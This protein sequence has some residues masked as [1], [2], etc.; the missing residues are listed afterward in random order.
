MPGQKGESGEK[1]SQGKTGDRGSAGPQGPAGP[2]GEPGNGGSATGNGEKGDK[3]ERGDKGTCPADACTSRSTGNDSKEVIELREEIARMKN[4]I[5][6]PFCSSMDNDD[7]LCGE[8]CSCADA[9]NKQRYV[10]DCTRQQPRFDCTEHAKHSN[11]SGLYKLKILQKVVKV[12]CDM[13][14]DGGGWTVVQRRQDGSQDFYKRW[15]AYRNG[16]GDVRDEYWFGLQNIYLLTTNHN[17]KVRFDMRTVDDKEYYAEY[18]A[19]KITDESDF[20]KLTSHGA[21]TGNAGQSLS[22]NLNY[23]FSTWDK[24]NDG[25]SGNCALLNRGAFWYRPNGAQGYCFETNING[26]YHRTGKVGTKYGT[27]IHW[28]EVTKNTGSLKYVDMKIKRTTN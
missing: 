18:S 15:Q 12:Y 21:Y 1:G 8:L 27:G 16:F 5:L 22:L 25:W 13:G 7:D 4:E 6:H 24:D 19:F 17:N 28:K 26:E 10:C 3:G 14:T 9:P 11:I 20:Y 23:K 2:K